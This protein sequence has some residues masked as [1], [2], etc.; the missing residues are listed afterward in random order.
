TDS[1]TGSEL[2]SLQVANLQGLHNSEF[3]CILTN[4]LF[5]D[6]TAVVTFSYQ[7]DTVKPFVNWYPQKE[8]TIP[9]NML[10]YEVNDSSLDLIYIRDNCKIETVSNSKT[11]T[12][13]LNGA[14]L[15]VGLSVIEWTITDKAGNKTICK[16][17]I[18]VKK[19][20][21]TSSHGY[22]LSEYRI[23]PNPSE[24]LFTIEGPVL[25]DRQIMVVDLMGKGVLQAQIM[26]K[27][28]TTIDMRGYAKGVYFLYVSSKEGA[29]TQ[30]IVVK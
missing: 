13:T 10:E 16:S 9:Q 23:Y 5:A 25:E 2:A 11:N 26:D 7:A 18:T 14:K 22:Q 30:K 12:A 15:P 17:N 27:R 28:K 3:K 6:T 29:Y 24:G 20:T 4:E 1:I 19:G 21:I 8:I